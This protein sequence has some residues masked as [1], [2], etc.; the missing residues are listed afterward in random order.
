MQVYRK[1]VLKH[2]ICDEC[3][4]K[5][6]VGFDKFGLP[7]GVRF[8]LKDGRKVDVC[9]SCIVHYGKEEANK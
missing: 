2:I 6:K 9:R 7:N 5:F 8:E 4:K 1:C 3:G